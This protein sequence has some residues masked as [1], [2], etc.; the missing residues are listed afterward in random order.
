MVDCLFEG[1]GTLDDAVEDD[2]LR[3]FS[4]ALLPDKRLLSLVGLFFA[5]EM[6]LH[7]NRESVSL[8]RS[9][10]TM[11]LGFFRGTINES[12]EYL[13]LFF[14]ES[15]VLLVLSRNEVVA[16]RFDLSRRDAFL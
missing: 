5:E 11:T 9:G 15:I 7:P 4:L 2:F 10:T 14:A 16:L 13:L 3:D 1:L 6:I 8:K 12:A